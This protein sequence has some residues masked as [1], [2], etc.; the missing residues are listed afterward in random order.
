M[1]L[2]PRKFREESYERVLEACKKAIQSA[3]SEKEKYVQFVV[4]LYVVY[5][6]MKESKP[7]KALILGSLV[8]DLFPLMFGEE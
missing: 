6:L 4:N 5:K 8:M 2:E 1:S 3:E 7:K